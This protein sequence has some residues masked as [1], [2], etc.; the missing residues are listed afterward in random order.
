MEALLLAHV[1]AVLGLAFY[2][3]E[4]Y[5]TVLRFGARRR[6]MIGGAAGSPRSHIAMAVFMALVFLLLPALFTAVPLYVAPV[7]VVINAVYL[8]LAVRFARR[9]SAERKAGPER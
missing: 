6:G 8:V 4:V 5:R 1:L 9:R 2:A 7:G 3:F